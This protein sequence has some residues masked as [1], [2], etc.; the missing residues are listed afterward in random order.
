MERREML[1]R[2]LLG[3]HEDGRDYADFSYNPVALQDDIEDT[4]CRS[5]QTLG[6]EDLGAGGLFR[7]SQMRKQKGSA[8]SQPFPVLLS[9]ALLPNKLVQV[10]RE[11]DNRVYNGQFTSD[12]NCFY[13][14]SQDQILVYNTSDP[15][16]WV[17]SRTIAGRSIRWTITDID[18][19]PC[20]KFLVYSTLDSHVNLVSLQPT[21]EDNPYQAVTD[22]RG[23]VGRTF[24]LADPN[25]E[26]F[27]V[28]SVKVSG[29][30]REIVAGTTQRTIE[31]YDLVRG[32]TV[33]RVPD[34]HQD[35]INSVCFANR[36]YSDVIFTGSD[37]STV[38]LWDRR[39]LSQRGVP[40]GV[41]IGHRE[42]V[43][44]VSSKGDGYYLLSNSKDQT[45]KLWD[46]RKMMQPD[47]AR[48]FQR[49]HR[50]FSGFDY[51]WQPY[52][53]AGYSKRLAADVSVQTFRGHQVLG[54][55]IRCYF[56]PLHS[57][58]QRFI[59]TGSADGS[60]VIYDTVTGKRA[61]TLTSDQTGAP[62]R[63]VS[64]HPEL[65]M[66][67]ATSFAGDISVFAYGAKDLESEEK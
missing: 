14:S 52:P 10:Y 48:D 65:P 32:Q 39:T 61:G 60:P 19:T 58:A 38:K 35:D 4:S 56:S 3:Q 63:D 33:Y 54:T 23:S 7:L 49:S 18:I 1:R 13:G 45:L 50:Y 37:D 51:R 29:D 67:T 41:F 15:R 9:S 6:A 66:V 22:G 59:L 5:H 31:V 8:L 47:T 42:G 12:G 34:A 40:E 28:F 43:A 57:T 2:L 36:D 30:G 24:E 44:H 17:R 27:G 20:R 62:A 53:G 26:G 64:W 21:E 11:F 16:A 55:L 46:V 25:G